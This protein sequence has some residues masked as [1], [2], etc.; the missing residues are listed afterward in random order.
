MISNNFYPK[1]FEKVIFRNF[2]RKMAENSNFSAFL[3]DFKRIFG[4]FQP[5]FPKK[6]KFS[7]KKWGFENFFQKTPITPKKMDFFAVFDEK[8]LKKRIFPTSVQFLCRKQWK[9]WFFAN[10]LGFFHFLKWILAIFPF[11]PIFYTNFSI[12]RIFHRKMQE[13]QIF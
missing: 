5:F 2:S 1:I 8:V 4:N 9:N 3:L 6:L 10:F 13:N 11:S 7:F 12:F